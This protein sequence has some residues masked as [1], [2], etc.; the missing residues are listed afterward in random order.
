MIRLSTCQYIDQRHHIILEGA[1]GNGKTFIACALGIAACRKFKTVRFI[2]M[3]ELLDDLNV[4]KSC[5]TFKKTVKSFHKMDLLILDEW[6]LRC[7]A[8][9]E[10][11]DLLEII[12]AR[13]N[14]STIFCTQYKSKEWYERIGLDE[15]KPVTEAIIDRIIH[16]AYEIMIDGEL[17]MRERHGLKTRESGCAR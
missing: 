4:A 1:S 3:P 5:G 16:N 2:R 14:P 12:E 11:Y 7:L 9:Q 17:S 6:L 10:S 15:D 13:C 8:P